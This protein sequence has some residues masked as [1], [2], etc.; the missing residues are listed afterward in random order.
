VP[1]WSVEVDF[2]GQKRS[3]WCMIASRH[4][5]THTYIDRNCFIGMRSIIVPGVRIGDHSI[6]LPGSFV[7]AKVPAR[8][9]V[10]GN[11]AQVV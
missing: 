6:V 2:K 5:H 3:F 8:S 10:V 11:P 4:F 1:R 7:N 9:M